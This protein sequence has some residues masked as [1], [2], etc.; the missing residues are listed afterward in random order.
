MSLSDQYGIAGFLATIRSE[1]PLVAGL[2]KG[3]DLTTLGLNLN[4]PE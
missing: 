2:A 3:Q 4:S 1:D